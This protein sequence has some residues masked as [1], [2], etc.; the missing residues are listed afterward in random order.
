MITLLLLLFYYPYIWWPRAAIRIF[1]L[2]NHPDFVGITPILIE[3]PESQ[4]HA[5]GTGKIPILASVLIFFSKTVKTLTLLEHE[6]ITLRSDILIKENDKKL[7]K[8]E[9]CTSNVSVT[10]KVC[11]RVYTA[12][13]LWLGSRF[14]FLVR[15][16]QGTYQNVS[17]DFSYSDSL[18][19]S[20]RHNTASYCIDKWPTALRLL[21]KA[22]GS[23]HAP[24]VSS[25]DCPHFLANCVNH[26]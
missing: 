13:F 22:K 2:S 3:N 9:Y 23:K 11:R 24:A 19:V 6:F 18:T 4:P 5:I 8:S 12:Q 20:R 16:T 26:K 10:V 7:Y 25:A 21:S 14:H 15:R 1:R 17:P